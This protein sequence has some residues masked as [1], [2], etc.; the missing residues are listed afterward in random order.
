MKSLRKTVA[1]CSA[2]FSE[3]SSAEAV[4]KVIYLPPLNFFSRRYGK[5]SCE[6]KDL[7]VGSDDAAES[8]AERLNFV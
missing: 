5:I 3:G 4:G 7:P 2:D 6:P 1:V 8:G